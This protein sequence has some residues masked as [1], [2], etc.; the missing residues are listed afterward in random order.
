MIRSSCSPNRLIRKAATIVAALLLSGSF[1][2]VIA[3]PRQPTQRTPRQA[4]TVTPKYDLKIKVMPEAHRVEATGTVLLPP[5]DQVRDRIELDLSEGMHDIQ[6]QVVEP[7]ESAGPVRIERTGARCTIFPARPVAKARAILMRV[8]YAGG[9]NISFVFYLGP[10]GSFASGINTAWYPQ[11]DRKRGVGSVRF[12]VPAGYKVFSVGA[13][14]D[15]PE[16]AAAGNYRFQVASPTRFSFAVGR[17]SVLRRAGP[18]PVSCYLLHDRNNVDKYVEGCR[19]VL[20]VLVK[21]FGPYPYPEFAI[22]E[23]PPGPAGEAGFSGASGEGFIFVNTPSLDQEFNTAYYG[24]EIGHQWWGNL[25][26]FGGLKGTSML[27]EGMAQFGSLLAVQAIDGDSAAERYR[28]TGYPGYINDQSG[29]GFLKLAAAGLDHPLISALGGVQSHELCDS[30]GL[31]AW[32]ILSRTIGPAQ[33]SRALHEVTRQYAYKTVSWERFVEIVKKAARSDVDWVFK[34][35]FEQTG[36]PELRVAWEWIGKTL[37]GTIYE[38]PPYYRLALEVLAE[39]S[40]AE[41]NTAESSAAESNT[42]QRLVKTVQVNGPRTE[43]TWPVEFQVSSMTLDP[44]FMVLHWTAEYRDQANALA[45]VT[46]GYD[47]VATGNPAEAYKEFEAGL[48]FIPS[49]DPYG[50]RF[51][52]EFGIA[53]LLIKDGK[54]EEAKQHLLKALA[55]PSF[56]SEDLPWVYYNLARV[57]KALKDDALFRSAMDSVMKEDLAAG[58]RTGAPEAAR[59]L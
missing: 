45:A 28:R 23:V 21:E 56:R 25:V 52:L 48:G 2:S 38:D 30:K 1:L 18:V 17:Y 33:F 59:R 26:G 36:A 22:I 5:A 49:Y 53:R 40:T 37:R 32:D 31:F 51:E 44:H 9:E 34:Q 16:Q 15:S 20:D 7:R 58:G 35:W 57:A 3:V 27:S 8:A 47:K 55:S 54:D 46:R 41:S 4:A 42:G 19:K 50:V 29:F 6:I 10:D 24:H 13:E 11:F 12:S 14:S 39:S 43:F